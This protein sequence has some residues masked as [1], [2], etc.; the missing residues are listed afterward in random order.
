MGL[1]RGVLLDIDGTLVDSNDAHAH[2]WVEALAEHGIEVPFARVRRLIGMGGDKLLPEV[3][4]IDAESP[5]GR[6]ILQRRGEIFQEKYMP[7]LKPFTG[8]RALVERMDSE[9]LTLVV[10]SS[11]KADELKLLLARAGVADLID[12]E[13]SSDDAESSKP[14][15]DIIE[16]A[17]ERGQ[18]TP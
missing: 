9:A 10:A 5:Q 7:S 14:D 6:A 18:L 16:A 3:A 2:A 11:A 15:P 8:A 17:L 4:K 12:G 1:L 13:T